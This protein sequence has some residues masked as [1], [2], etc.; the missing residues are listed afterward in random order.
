[1]DRTSKQSR[2]AG[3]VGISAESLEAA[4]V[5]EVWFVDSG[6]GGGG[7]GGAL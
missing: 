5:K 1:M 2:G 4:A 6:D 7:G 3:P